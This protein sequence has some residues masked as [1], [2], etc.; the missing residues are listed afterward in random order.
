LTVGKRQLAK[1]QLT[2]GKGQ[3]TIDNRQVAVGKNQ[4]AIFQLTVG[5]E[6]LAVG[7]NS[8]G[9]WQKQ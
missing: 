1:F 3:L 5:K 9:N 2:V 8:V 6:Q 7:N 4:L